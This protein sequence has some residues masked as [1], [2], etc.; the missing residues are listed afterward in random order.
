[1]PEL[2]D[3]LQATGRRKQIGSATEFNR[4]MNADL[5]G[6]AS[7]TGM[8]VSLVKSLGTSVVKA[9]DVAK[10]AA[11][12]SNLRSLADMFI[13]PRSVELIRNANNRGAR[14]GF[15]EGLART[16]AETGATLFDP[17]GAR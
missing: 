17:A 10:R 2:L 9:G 14:I 6:A 1:M 13:D 7:P 12:R 8:A 3:V 15:G 4:S 5:G 16:G 11:L